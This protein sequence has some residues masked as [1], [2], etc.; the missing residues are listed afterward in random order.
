MDVHP[1]PHYMGLPFPND[2]AGKEVLWRGHPLESKPG[3]AMI[4]SEEF[5]GNKLESLLEDYDDLFQE[6]AGLPPP[7]NCDHCITLLPGS[8]PVVVHPYRYPQL[9]KDEIERQ[10]TQM[11]IQG[12]IRPSKSPFSSLV[13]LVKKKDGSWRFC[14]DYRKLN[15]RTV[16]EKFPIPIVE[17]LL[18]ELHGAQYF[19]KLDLRSGY[20]Q[21]RMDPRDIK[22]IAFRTH[23]RHLRSG[24]HQIRMDPRDIKKIAFRTHQIDS[25]T[26]APSIF[27]ALMNE[28]FQP[29]LR[30]FVLDFFDDILIYNPMRDIHLG[31]CRLVFELLK[32]NLLFLKKSKCSV[33]Q[34]QVSYLEFV[35]EC[36]AS[37]SGFGAVLQQL[38]HPIDFFSRKIIE[39]H[40]KLT[41]YERELI[42]LAKAVIHWRSCLW[43]RHFLIQ[44]DHYSLKYLLEQRITTYPQQHWISKLMGFD[45]WV[46]FKASQLNHVADALSHCHEEEP[47]IMALSIP[48]AEIFDKIRSEVNSNSELF[49]LLCR[50]QSGE[51]GPKWETRDSL[52]F[53][54]GRIFLPGESPLLPIV[55]AIFHEAGHEGIQK[56]LHRL[57]ADFYWPDISMDFI[58]GL[59]RVKGKSVLFVIVDRLSKYAHF[60]P[61]AHPYTAISVVGIFF[62]EIFRL[63]GMP[64]SIVSDRDKVFLSSFW[65]ELFRLCGTKLSFSSAYHPQTDGQTEVVNRTIEMYLRYLVR[66]QPQKWLEWLPWVEYCYN[67]SFHTALG[68]TPFQL[69]YGREPPRLLSY[70]GGSTRVAAV[71]R[72]LME[73][74]EVLQ[75][76][77]AHLLQSQ[78]RTKLAFDSS[79][80]ELSFAVGDWVWL[81]LQPYRQ[82]SMARQRHHKLLPKYFGPFQVPARIG[83]IAYRLDLPPDSRIHDVFH[84]S[85]LKPYKGSPPDNAGTLPQMCDGQ[86]LPVPQTSLRSRLNKVTR[87]YLV[88]WAGSSI[89]DATWES[90]VKFLSVYP[91]FE[92]EDQLNIEK[93]SDDVDAFVGRHYNRKQITS[94]E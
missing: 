83:S 90:P 28:V 62:T 32:A 22:K 86:A 9:Q 8:A 35:V 41:A 78:Q 61:L 29:Y 66:D 39:H 54:K 51:E 10:C 65:Q 24:Y 17:E 50:V 4:R 42:G 37:G 57:R 5:M 21:I 58:E 16:K 77:R 27:Q 2:E 46:E 64:E 33:G 55:I 93:G 68:A 72:A 79:H 43:G 48:C 74:D 85:L 1:R 19:T 84:V 69:V 36:D 59:P 26:N 75:V 71:D 81:R 80:R 56:T 14:I 18:D 91:T 53:Y 15:N 67:T 87:E 92:L 49:G 76:A 47:I 23:H 60:I 88:H 45:F 31:H 38:G 25:L 7:R 34:S 40:L 3:T 73:R 82:L 63:H 30:K 6:P 70:S 89:E 94:L 12:I 11:L 52:I 44:T 20:H 13:L